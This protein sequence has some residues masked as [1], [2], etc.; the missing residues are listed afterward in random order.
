MLTTSSRKIQATILTGVFV[1]GA[2]IVAG[3]AFPGTKSID[4]EARFAAG[5]KV[6][7]LSGDRLK[8]KDG[9]DVE[10]AGIRL[11]YDHEPFAENARRTLA[12]WIDDEGV[13]LQFDEAREHRKDRILAYVYANDTFINLRLVRDGLAFVKLRSGNRKHAAQFLAAQDAARDEGKGIWGLV[14]PSTQNELIGDDVT[15][16]FHRPGCSKLLPQSTHSQI[17]GTTDALSKGMAPCGECR[18]LDR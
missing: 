17:R 16:T 10:F 5:G 11:P 18:P 1:T 7:R 8:L 12:K 15:A 3:F 6:K 4:P 2:V 9:R 14:S 13:R